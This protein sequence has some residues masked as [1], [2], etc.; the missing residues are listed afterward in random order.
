MTVDHLSTA[1]QCLPTASMVIDQ[2]MVFV[3]VN[4][5]YCRAVQRSR[6]DLIGRYLF[7]AFPDTPERIEP[8]ERVF[9]QTLNGEITKLERQPYKLRMPNGILEDRL[10]DIEQ[11]PIIAKSGEITG[12]IQFC[13][14]VTEREAFRKE[15]DLV[16]AELN[17]RVRNTLAVVQSV[18]EHTGDVSPTIDAFLESFSG[19]L[20][21]LGRNFAALSDSNWRGL[22]FAEIIRI[23]LAPLTGPTLEGVSLSGPRITLGVKATKDASMIFHE[24]IT[25]AS[26]YGF[27]T[28]PRGKL[29]IEWR[30]DEACLHMVWTETGLTDLKPPTRT[31]FGFQLFEMFPNLVLDKHFARDG[32]KL[33]AAIPITTISNEIVFA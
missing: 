19:R 21:A 25:N 9:R 8:V 10:W 1:F 13:E 26:K 24:L 28:T 7:D 23:E 2:D 30:L 20:A 22:D 11:H 3:D 17:H 5:A 32:L 18:A 29:D 27:L 14:D 33:H 31:G 15:R 4:P 16:S 6:E 12:M